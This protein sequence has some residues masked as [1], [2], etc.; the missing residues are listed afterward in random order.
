MGCDLMRMCQAGRAMNQQ[1]CKLAGG[2]RTPGRSQGGGEQE[3]G[4]EISSLKEAAFGG[5]SVSPGNGNPGS[6]GSVCGMSGRA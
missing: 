3:L 2:H 5:S 6:W 4:L 1:G